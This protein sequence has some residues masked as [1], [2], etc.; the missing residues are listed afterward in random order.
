MKK[1]K[2]SYLFL[3]VSILTT[4]CIE[5]KNIEYVYFPDSKIVKAE[6][7]AKTNSEDKCVKQYFKDGNLH[8]EY[9]FTGKEYNGKYLEYFKNGMLKEEKI[10]K[11]GELDGLSKTYFDNG[12]LKYSGFY[13]NGIP[14]K[15]GTFY[16]ENGKVKAENRFEKGNLFYVKSYAEKDSSFQENVIPIISFNKD[17]L[18]FMDTLI[19]AFEIP[20]IDNSNIN[21]DDCIIEFD[22]GRDSLDFKEYNYPTNKIS[23]EGGKVTRRFIIEDLGRQTVYG[24]TSHLNKD[25]QK[26][27]FES[28]RKVFF[29]KEKDKN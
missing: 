28:F 14:L 29:V 24:Y 4:S 8:K 25:G 16:Y 27:E 17:T 6:I 22:L 23:M 21:R 5:N 3:L 11:E 7:S 1:N 19:V 9:C 20:H 12:Q 26:L 15:N 13:K 10:L 2:I 18:F